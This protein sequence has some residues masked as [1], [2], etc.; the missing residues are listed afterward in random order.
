VPGL[1]RELVARMIPIVWVL[2]LLPVIVVA[3]M[4]SSTT[5]PRDFLCMGVISLCLANASF[6][7]IGNAGRTVYR[8]WDIS[9]EVGK[10]ADGATLID[11]VPAPDGW[12]HVTL[13]YWLQRAGYEVHIVDSDHCPRPSLSWRGVQFCPVSEGGGLQR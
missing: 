4:H 7:F 6:A 3:A 9:S 5:G 12:M 11:L 1:T 2:P 13:A 8:W 10:A